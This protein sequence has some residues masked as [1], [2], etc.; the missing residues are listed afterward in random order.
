MLLIK[1]IFRD[2]S[3]LAHLSWNL[4]NFPGRLGSV[5]PFVYK[6]VNF[7]NIYLLVQNHRV[8][9]SCHKA[10]L[11]QRI[12]VRTNEGTRPFSMWDNYEIADVYWQNLKSVFSRTDAPSNLSTKHP[13]VKGIQFCSEEGP[14]PFLRGDNYEIPNENTLIQI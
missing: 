1:T 11:G 7:S 3:Y 8:K 6:S 12:K 9:Q 5:C 4:M 14:C 2:L 10:S 13:W